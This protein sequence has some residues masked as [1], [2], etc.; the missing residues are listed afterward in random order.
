MGAGRG[1]AVLV[2]ATLPFGRV[3]GVEINADW[4]EI[5]RQA[6]E[7]NRRRLA[8]N[9]VEMVTA[10]IL[11]YDYP[12]DT[13]IVYLFCPFVGDTFQRFAERLLEFVDRVEHPVRLLYNYPFEHDRLIALQ[14]FEVVD[15]CT[16]YWPARNLMG[17]EVIVTYLIQPRSSKEGRQAPPSR[18]R[19]STVP[20]RAGADR[21]TRALCSRRTRIASSAAHATG[22]PPAE[23]L[24]GHSSR[25]A[26]LPFAGN[27]LT[28]ASSGARLST[29][30][31]SRSTGSI[32]RT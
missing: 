1:R 20:P 2:A 26:Q 5:A 10:N 15:V 29:R 25:E 19:C 7:R 27:A 14:R 4:A 23:R 16:A 12:D 11:Q 17:P 3:I 21:T 30:S 32:A 24:A 22:V 13:T 6:I 8:C 18:H 9:D 31:C 28:S